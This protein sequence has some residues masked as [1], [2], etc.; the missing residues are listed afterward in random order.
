MLTKYLGTS[1]LSA[2]SEVHTDPLLAYAFGMSK[3][4]FYWTFNAIYSTSK[5]A[6]SAHYSC[7]K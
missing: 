6:Q 4:K 5:R 2:G 1:Y 3:V 7:L